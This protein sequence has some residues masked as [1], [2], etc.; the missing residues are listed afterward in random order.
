MSTGHGVR[1]AVICG[2]IALSLPRNA[3]VANTS[4]E[5]VVRRGTSPIND[6]ICSLFR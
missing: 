4:E 2:L 3:V 5:N 1:P 6:I